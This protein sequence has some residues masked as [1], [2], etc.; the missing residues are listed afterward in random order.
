MNTKKNKI[1]QNKESHA[2]QQQAKPHKRKYTEKEKI[3]CLMY[4]WC[5]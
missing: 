5:C 4:C 2:K 1:G 3:T